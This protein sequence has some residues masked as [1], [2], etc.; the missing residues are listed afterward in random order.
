MIK[1]L[2][3]VLWPLVRITGPSQ[4][5][6]FTADVTFTIG[7]T[8]AVCPPVAASQTKGLLQGGKPGLPSIWFR[9][10]KCLD[11]QL[12]NGSIT[13]DCHHQV[14]I[15]IFLVIIKRIHEYI[16]GKNIRKDFVVLEK[17]LRSNYIILDLFTNS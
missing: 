1:K 8:R 9:L 5:E 16:W 2:F 15:F 13:T 14:G 6:T 7:F 3:Q 12:E 4:V 10:E 17:A 11:I